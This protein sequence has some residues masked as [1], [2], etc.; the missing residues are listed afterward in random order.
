MILHL[1]QICKSILY[2]NWAYLNISYDYYSKHIKY[3]DNVIYLFQLLRV[4]TDFNTNYGSPLLQMEYAI[5]LVN[6]S[7]NNK[8]KDNELRI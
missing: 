7:L 6:T 3:T 1:K 2:W 4:A 8:R 5:V